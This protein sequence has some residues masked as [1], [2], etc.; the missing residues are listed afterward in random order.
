MLI[1]VHI[2]ALIVY[3]MKMQVVLTAEPTGWSL[4]WSS[5]TSLDLLKLPHS[6]E[7][8]FHLKIS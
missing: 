3:K 4:S 6:S 7:K 2:N 5:S 8:W 1:R